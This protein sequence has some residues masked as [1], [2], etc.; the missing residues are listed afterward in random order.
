MEFGLLGPL[1][2]WDKG[3]ELP[4]GGMRQR[5]VLRVLLLRANELVPTARLVDEVWVGG[6]R[7][8]R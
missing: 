5:S 1:A 6:R 3:R 4:L 8:P 2:V 7:R